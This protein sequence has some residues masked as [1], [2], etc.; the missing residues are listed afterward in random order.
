MAAG[1]TFRLLSPIMHGEDIRAFQQVLKKQFDNWGVKYPVKLDGDYAVPTREATATVLHGLGIL[2]T[3][4]SN[5]VTP[6]LQAK[7]RNKNLS[8]T[9]R[10]RRV[11]RRLWRRR[12][13]DK[14]AAGGVAPP[15][16]KIFSSAWGWHG[17]GH[18]GVD[19][20][21]PAEAPIF[22][23]CDA[24][25]ID[26]R[27]AG[28]WGSGAVAHGGHP[29]SD[30]DGI[31]QLECLVN[32][33]PFRKGMHFGYGHSENHTVQVGQTVKAGQRLGNAG[34]ARGWHVH[35][36]VNSGNTMKGIGDRDPMPFVKYARKHA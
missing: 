16:A 26:V 9:E 7:V 20:T 12:L 21:C 11:Q 24:K 17:S 10:V 29:I 28:W 4:M 2:K 14:Y 23:L 25:V 36:M 19:L 22:A 15:L 33:G 18:D 6:E 31:V 27:S 3:E 30:G 32:L 34:Y 8:P 1:R 35:F 5:G 13:R